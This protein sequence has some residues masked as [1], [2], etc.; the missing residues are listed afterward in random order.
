MIDSAS[1]PVNPRSLGNN[2]QQQFSISTFI[3]TPNR[4]NSAISVFFQKM[5][6]VFGL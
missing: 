6:D 4:N 3:K 2:N 1:K 5:A